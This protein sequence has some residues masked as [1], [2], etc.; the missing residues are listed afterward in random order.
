[1]SQNHTPG[2]WQKNGSH[3][4]GP[5]PERTPICQII[6]PG[7]GYQEE[8]AANESLIKAAP[9]LL[10]ACKA[11]HQAIDSLLARIIEL[12]REFRPSQS[13]EW[14]MLLQGNDAIAKAEGRA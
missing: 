12:D 7:R 1:M 8:A 2:T 13:R 9:D 10:E 4:Y 14:P 6:Y 11:Q 5:D 3:I